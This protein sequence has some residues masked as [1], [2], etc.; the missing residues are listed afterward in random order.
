MIAHCPLPI[1]PER[2]SKDCRLPLQSQIQNPSSK[3]Q[4]GFTL[5]EVMISVALV[6]VLILGVNQVFKMTADTVGAGQTMSANVRDSRA[7]QTV[8][9]NDLSGA[10]TQNPPMFMIAASRVSAFRNRDDA[11]GDRD[12][13]TEAG[14]RTIDLDGDNAEGEAAVLGEL[15]SPATYNF[16]SHRIDR[17]GFFARDLFTRQTANDGQYSNNTTSFEAWV[18]YGHLKMANNT[19]GTPFEPGENDAA[20]HNNLHASDFAVGRMVTL[21][22]DPPSIGPGEARLVRGTGSGTPMTTENPVPLSPLAFGTRADDKG[23]TPAGTQRQGYRI[24]DSRYD[25]AGITMAN[26][27]NDLREYVLNPNP[28]PPP[29]PKFL[30]DNPSWWQRMLYASANY[31]I[32]MSAGTSPPAFRYE[33]DRFVTKPLTSAQAARL[34]PVLL[35]GCSQFIVEFAGDY[36]TQDNNP[37]PPTGADPMTYG[38]RITTP[39][40]A[41][42]QKPDGIIDFVI[43]RSTGVPVRSIRWYGMPRDVAGL[44]TGGPNGQI[45]V[46]SASTPSLATVASDP[47]V[48]VLPVGIVRGAPL[49]FEREFPDTAPGTVDYA[50]VPGM[51]PTARYTC[52]W[53]PD[54]FVDTDLLLPTSLDPTLSPLPQMLRI[55]FVLDEPNGRL[56]EGQTYEFVITLPR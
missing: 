55:T 12:A 21:L 7:A 44:N 41:A 24:E 25:L 22:K 17:L 9:Y 6:L 20:N 43:D 42:G 29:A 48:D 50:N 10:V 53:G 45:P 39:N 3:I 2:Q 5:V 52:M 14:I 56:A 1:G 31:P 38:D 51:L 28:A 47:P 36:I 27:G 23:D 15:I 4:N 40:P 16:R 49:P 32:T 35:N 18:W 33:A 26:F 19:T 13:G 37:P 11:A 8:I 30:V 34:T 46:S 54:V